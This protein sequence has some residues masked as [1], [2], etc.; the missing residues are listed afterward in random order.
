MNSIPH[1]A[2]YSDLAN[3]VAVVTGG[4]RGIGAATARALAANGAKVAVNGRD[5]TAIDG[6][7]TEIQRKGG[8]AIGIAADCTD[9]SALEHVRQTVEDE[10]GP[11]DGLGQRVMTGPMPQLLGQAVLLGVGGCEVTDQAGEADHHEN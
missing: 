3:K 6:V 11:V 2:V 10:L 7:V 9:F 1:L 4:S 5:A 8:R